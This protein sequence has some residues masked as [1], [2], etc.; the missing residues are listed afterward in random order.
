VLSGLSSYMV[1]YLCRTELL[2]PSITLIDTLARSGYG[3]ARLFSFSDVLLARS[4]AKLLAA[5]VSVEAIRTSVAVLEQKLGKEPGSLITTPVSIVG[6]QIYLEALD[7]APVALSQHG[8]MVFS[9]MLDVDQ[10]R[11]D[12]SKV[13]TARSKAD[14]ARV[15]R[16]NIDAASRCE[17]TSS[18]RRRA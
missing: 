10:I 13:V 15:S 4:L 12:A 14:K 1:T 5:G 11:V 2:R 16:H 17:Q 18:N 9:Y 3:R 8:Q 6:E 7:G